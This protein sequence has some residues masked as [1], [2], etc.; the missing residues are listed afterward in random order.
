MNRQIEAALAMI[1]PD[2]AVS[3][4]GGSHVA[5]LADAMRAA[6]Y[7]GTV[8]SPSVQTRDYCRQIGLRVAD[9]VAATDIAF[10]GCDGIAHDFSLLKSNGGIFT[11][12]RQYAAHT[13]KYVILAPITRW[14]AV[15]D[16][17]IPL[18]LEVVPAAS[19][20]V[21][22]VL[23]E[24]GLTAVIRVD[25]DNRVVH[26]QSGN[27][28]VDCYAESW[29]SIEETDAQIRALEG[30]VDTSYLHAAADVLIAENAD[31]DITVLRRED[32]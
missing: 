12:E 17:A 25:A 3:L 10:D 31:G 23:S 18:T 9:S 5:M 30:I 24:F 13:K 32:K 1:R 6:G 21:H 28:L 8:I 7:S 20:S 27:V 19:A 26:T 2:M 22:D 14:Q 29:A 15:L 11:S 4:G 16:S